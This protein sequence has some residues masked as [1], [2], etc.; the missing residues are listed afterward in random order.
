MTAY[1]IAQ[2]MDQPQFIAV[3]PS[4]SGP[5]G[6]R[7]PHT[8]IKSQVLAVLSQQNRVYINPKNNASVFLLIIFKYLL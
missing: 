1:F 3:N 5:P 8:L 2:K 4:C 7:T 6:A